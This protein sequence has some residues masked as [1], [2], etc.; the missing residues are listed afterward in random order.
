MAIAALVSNPHSLH[1]HQAKNCRSIACLQHLAHWDWKIAREGKKERERETLRGKPAASHRRRFKSSLFSPKP[2]RMA[3]FL[4]TPSLSHCQLAPL[5]LSPSAGK[6]V[7][8]CFGHLKK[9]W[10]KLLQRTPCKS[11]RMRQHV[12]AMG[13]PKGCGEDVMR[14]PRG[15]RKRRGQ[16]SVSECI[17]HKYLRRAAAQAK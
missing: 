5:T 17:R 4:A 9:T 13:Q 7:L 14:E 1:Q 10:S 8:A 15:G 11:F 6:F 16:V 3:G 12:A 2:N